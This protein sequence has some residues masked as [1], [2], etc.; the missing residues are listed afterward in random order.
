MEREKTPIRSMT[1]LTNPEALL[2]SN[3]H[4]QPDAYKWCWLNGS[5]IESA[6]ASVSVFDR[7]YL[8]GDGLFETIRIHGGKLFEW[9]R[10]WDR[11]K[12]GCE[13]LTIR[14]DIAEEALKTS[15][16]DLVQKNQLN[17]CMARIQISRGPDQEATSHLKTRRQHGS[18]HYIQHPNFPSTDLSHG[19]SFYPE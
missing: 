5:F 8:Y 14:L 19:G 16:L 10:H 12:S 6:N 13:G 9:Q 7:G 1:S 15:I 2:S 4:L 18:L 3:K 11:L 17:E